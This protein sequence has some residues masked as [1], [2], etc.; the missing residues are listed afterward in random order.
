MP[1]NN[2]LKTV[3]KLDNLFELEINGIKFTLI[4]SNMCVKQELRTTKYIKP[5]NETDII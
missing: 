2:V 3:P 1:K 4:G 5:K